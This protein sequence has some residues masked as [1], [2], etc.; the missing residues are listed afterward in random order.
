MVSPTPLRALAELVCSVDDPELP[1]VTI[2]DLG[3]V[4]DVSVVDGTVQVVL[5]PTYIGCP[6]TEQIRDDV[7]A[8]LA[9]A[10]HASRIDFVMSPPW[11]TDWI[12]DEGRRKLAAAGIAPPTGVA[13]GDVTALV[14]LPVQ[15]PRCGSRRTRRVAEFGATACKAAYVCERCR[16]PFESFKPR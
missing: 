12:S 5:A 10:G 3:M 2:G 13:G 9:A 8:A 11:S 14:D 7:A 15:C 1:Q 16:E 4:R 6:A